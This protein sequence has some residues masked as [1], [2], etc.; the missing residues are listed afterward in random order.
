MYNSGGIKV[1]SIGRVQV[2]DLK[3]ALMESIGVRQS[4]AEFQAVGVAAYT[5]EDVNETNRDRCFELLSQCWWDQILHGNVSDKS[6]RYLNIFTMNGHPNV[7]HGF[8]TGVRGGATNVPDP[9]LCGGLYPCQTRFDRFVK[10]FV[11]ERGRYYREDLMKI[12]CN[13]EKKGDRGGEFSYSKL[14]M[15]RKWQMH[16]A[17][18][19]WLSA[20]GRSDEAGRLYFEMEDVRV[21][22]MEG[23]FPAGWKKRQWGCLF[24]GCTHPEDRPA[25]AVIPSALPCK[26]E[27][28][29]QGTECETFGTE[30][31]TVAV[32]WCNMP[33]STCIGTGEGVLKGRCTCNKGF[34]AKKN[35][36]G[37]TTCVKREF[38]CKYFGQDCIVY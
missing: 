38:K 30:T 16:L 3:Q 9:E 21:M 24:S 31:C 13:A 35:S 26:D 37:E 14:V 28:W 10:P 7:E 5:K 15:N 6:N 20:F 18:D 17:T 29:W 19:G 33:D 22:Y 4:L 36:L 8:S 11:N 2:W 25:S 34:C 1:D 27:G 32:G 23:K 12:V